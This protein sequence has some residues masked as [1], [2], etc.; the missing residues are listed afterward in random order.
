VSILPAFDEDAFISYAHN[1]DDK[2]ALEP[3]GWVAQLHKDLEERVPVHLGKGA[4]LWRDSDIRSNDDFQRRI[5]TKLMRTATLLSVISPSF[6]K[7][8]WCLRELNEFASYAER[9]FGIRIDEEKWRIFKIEKVKVDRNELPELLQGRSSYKFYGP[10]PED[11]ERVHEFRPAF[12]GE[13]QR[14][15][16]RE[17]D[18]L[19]KDIA[20]VL[21]QMT[22]RAAGEAPPPAILPAVYLAETTEDMDEE[23]KAIRRDLKDRGYQVL[24]PENLPYR[25]KEFRQSVRDYLKRSVL[26]VHLVG[27]QYGLIP[28]GENEKSNAWLQNELAVERAADPNYVRLIWMPGSLQAS[29]PRQRKFIEY[30]QNDSGAQRGADVLEVGFEDLKGTVQ[31][32]LRQIQQKQERKPSRPEPPAPAPAENAAPELLRIYIICDPLDLKSAGLV[33]LKKQLFER[34]YEAIVPSVN[35]DEREALLEHAE[36]LEICDACIIYYGNGSEKWFGTKLREL[37]KALNGRPRPIVA[38]AVYISAPP[39]AAKDE[40]QTFEALVLRSG[41]SFSPETL[42]PFFERLSVARKAASS[43]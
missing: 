32:Q 42:Q 41:A 13:Y 22:R 29:D 20:T 3:R 5:A 12:G 9:T 4:A 15:Y 11:G 7:R 8:E 17:L 43:S 31:Q 24:P 10:D 21:D 2:L 25:L 27:K 38:R 18:D 35:D 26:S 28:E 30:L 37:R 39:T 36:N 40:L 1:D 6:L 33:A 14:A 23:A 34:G 19:A 16:Y